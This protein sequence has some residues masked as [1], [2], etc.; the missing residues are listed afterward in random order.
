MRVICC[1][2]DS[3]EHDAISDRVYDELCFC[4]Q[5]EDWLSPKG[6]YRKYRLDKYWEEP[7]DRL[8][9]DILIKAGLREMFAV[10]IHHDYFFFDLLENIPYWYTFLDPERNC[11]VYFPSFYP[12]GDYHFFFNED[13]SCGLFGHPWRKEIYV[14]GEGLIQLFDENSGELGIVAI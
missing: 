2:R 5:S 8:V 12:D 9:R 4:S 10:D 14:L 13:I 1:Y 3:E 6:A 7:Q 11:T